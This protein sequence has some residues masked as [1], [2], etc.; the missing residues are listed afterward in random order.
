MSSKIHLSHEDKRICTA[1]STIMIAAAAFLL[2]MLVTF[3]DVS[4]ALPSYVQASVSQLQA[5]S[6]TS[7][8]PS[9]ALVLPFTTDDIPRIQ[10]NIASWSL[11]APVCTPPLQIGLFFYFSGN[12]TTYGSSL[13][14]E[15]VVR[16]DP[17]FM[18]SVMPCLSEVRTIF[19]E[20]T[21]EEDTYPEGPSFMFFNI[22]RA[23]SLQNALQ[24]YS[25]MFW[26]EWDT[27]PIRPLWL[28]AL[29]KELDGNRF[30]MK[31]SQYVGGAAF[32]GTVHYQENW[33]WVGHLNGE[34]W[35][36]LRLAPVSLYRP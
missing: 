36:W 10:D 18:K 24:A 8:T 35:L 15:D 1:R 4:R 23:P 32:D 16:A 29:V 3:H 11:L 19:A 34:D 22:F 31:G 12:A 7:L 33:N 5:S 30:W 25:H 28:N 13:R 26:M 27:R 17:V 6:A 2:A 21:P 14:M 20:L 9:L